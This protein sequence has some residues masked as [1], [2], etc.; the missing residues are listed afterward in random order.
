MS[1]SQQANPPIPDAILGSRDA[2]LEEYAAIFCDD[3]TDGPAPR[4][5]QW[6]RE[7]EADLRG[8]TKTA[9]CL[10]GGGIRSAAF[11][12]GALQALATNELLGEFNYL[13]TVSGG[14]Y[15]GAWLATIM[16]GGGK[17]N[18][19]LSAANKALTDPADP[20][21]RSLRNYTNFL[22]PEGGFGSSDTWSAIVLWLRNVLLNWL[23][24]GPVLLAVALV[25]LLY[26]G[27][28]WDVS[29]GW[30]L[31]ALIAGLVCLLGGTI[32]VCRSV[33][34]H[35]YDD[36]KASKTGPYG[37]PAATVQLWVVAPVLTWA[38][39]APLWFSAKSAS[40]YDTVP[41]LSWTFAP[42]SL[43]AFVALIAGYVIAALTLERRHWAGFAWNIGFWAI[44]AAL[45]AFLLQLGATLGQ[46]MTATTLAVLGPLW[47][48][49]AQ[50][51]HSTLYVGLR[52]TA[53]YAEL[54]R[55]WL[56]RLNG[57]K[58]IP[59]LAWSVLAAITLIL[60]VLVFEQ[61]RSTYAA[62][63][64]FASGPV[65]AWLGRS[66]KSFGAKT[67][68]NATGPAWWAGMAREAAITLA[69]LLF[70]ATLFMLLGRLGAIIVERLG[71][72]LDHPWLIALVLIILLVLLSAYCGAR[73][74]INR[75]SM[76]GVYRNRLA[77]AFIGT[78]RPP[79]ERK[80]DAYTRFDPGDN[81]RMQDLYQGKQQRGILFPV[82]NVTLN[83][84]EGAPSGWAERKAAPFTITP[85]RAGAACL[86]GRNALG[87]A[88]GR[89]VRTTEYGGQEHEAGLEDVESGITLGT[90]MTISGA[91]VS[92]NMGYHSSPATAFVMTLFDV[93]LGAWLPNPAVTQR[94]T[95][96]KPSNALFPMFNEMLGRANDRRA[97]IYLSDGGHF[98]NLGVYEMLRRRCH[99]IVA[100]DAGCDP[101][102]QYADLGAALRL[103]AIDFDIKVRFVAPIIKGKRDLDAAG[104]YARIIYRDAPEGHLLYLKPWLPQALPADILAYFSTHADFPHQTTA[105]QFFNESQFESYR[106]LA[107]LIVANA[108]SGAQTLDDM[109][110]AAERA[111]ARQRAATVATAPR[112]QRKPPKK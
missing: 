4:A 105:N 49:G 23:V 26:C 61:W 87:D 80:P 110:V 92:P 46:Q 29:S 32:M 7:H 77:R 2:L 11:C 31:T 42:I 67:S 24:F 47:V 20:A 109:V 60:P 100:I 30:G 69:T 53:A 14:G 78:A 68:A 64:G 81:L 35:A 84:L 1:Q 93:R 52:W 98:D 37:V 108:F 44:G 17:G 99:I 16:H 22:I 86:G 57:E 58:V 12:L 85:L 111:A 33:P 9:L 89:Y 97:D 48:I 94:W 73:I 10:S 36:N 96:A 91:A 27:L 3:W 79:A 70:A 50:V 63:V 103:A 5:R 104:A 83:L 41:F 51:L 82:V 38:F 65:G 39:L 34:T 107:E 6:L 90:A 95:P 8:T 88:E 62:V 75:F 21:L 72:L 43:G 101:D 74:N 18:G 56:A 106:A 28:L 112:W 19:A 102:Y 15:I 66:A 25:P 13:S 76:H 55:E 40:R 59:V 71:S 45:S 54:D